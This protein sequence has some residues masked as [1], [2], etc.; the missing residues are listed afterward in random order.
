MHTQRALIVWT[1]RSRGDHDRALMAECKL[2]Q[3]V[4]LEEN[5][6]VLQLLDVEVADIMPMATD[7]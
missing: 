4:D 1:L 6:G 5:A 3:W 2:P 7:D